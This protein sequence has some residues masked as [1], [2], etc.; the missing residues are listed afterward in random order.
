MYGVLDAQQPRIGAQVA[1]DDCAIADTARQALFGQTAQSVRE[2][3]A[4]PGP[5]RS[6]E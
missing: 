6:I 4:R 5:N 2:A 1:G 3:G